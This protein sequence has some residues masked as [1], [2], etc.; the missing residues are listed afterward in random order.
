MTPYHCKV[1]NFSTTNKYNF[2]KHISTKKHMVTTQKHEKLTS[3]IF[4]YR[5]KMQTGTEGTEKMQ[6]D[7]KVPGQDRENDELGEECYKCSVCD[8]IFKHKS[9]LYRHKKYNCRKN[10]DRLIEICNEKDSTIDS[11]QKKI[12]SNDKI[13]NKQDVVDMIKTYINKENGLELLINEL[14]DNNTQMCN[15]NNHTNNASLSYSNNQ[16]CHNINNSINNIGSINNNFIVNSY[17]KENTE[18]ITDKDMIEFCKTPRYMIP[19]YFKKLHFDMDHPENH[20]IIIPNIKEK[21]IQLKKDTGWD[22]ID[23]EDDDI[24]T[25][26]VDNSYNAMTYFFENKEQNDPQFIKDNMMEHEIIGYKKY[27]DMYEDE[28]SID[29]VNNPELQPNFNLAKKKCHCVVIE[30]KRNIKRL[31]KE[32]KRIVKKKKN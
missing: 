12:T 2:D 31:E 27:T 6:T 21:T 18:Y 26:F 23:V 28:R 7:F 17:G 11:L 22:E 4:R 9:S 20:N 15:S 1:C 30:G 14:Q 5:K 3:C 8:E 10:P 19:K 24:I 13:F 16:N 25:D 32:R 29:K